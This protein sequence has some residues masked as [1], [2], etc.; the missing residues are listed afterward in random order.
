M[1]SAGN[2]MS[3]TPVYPAAYTDVI[4]VSGVNADKSFAASGTTGCFSYS[5]YG[6]HVD[7]SAPFTANSTR[8]PMAE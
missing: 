5:N 3:N 6:S 8:P 2:F 1:A 7:L 4:G